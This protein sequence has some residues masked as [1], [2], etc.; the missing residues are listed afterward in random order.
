M[1]TRTAFERDYRVAC[2]RYPKETER[3]D[4][5]RDKLKTDA[6]SYDWLLEQ[7]HLIS[8]GD[9]TYDL[10]HQYGQSPV[11]IRLHYVHETRCLTELA[12]I[13]PDCPLFVEVLHDQTQQA[14]PEPFDCQQERVPQDPHSWREA[15][16][17][18]RGQHCYPAEDDYV[19][20][21]RT[22]PF[23]R[24]ANEDFWQGR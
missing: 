17:A 15:P 13:Y 21:C 20:E 16:D 2:E 9:D 24:H 19:R 14:H 6:N 22:R 10:A 12:V 1:S 18:S 7:Q 3:L 11:G 5:Y 23:G 8:R 4:Q